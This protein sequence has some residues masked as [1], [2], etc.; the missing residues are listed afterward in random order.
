VTHDLER[1]SA[2]T[3][4]AVNVVLR[5]RVRDIGPDTNWPYACR[6]RDEDICEACATYDE[7]EGCE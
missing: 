7:D 1:V 5:Q 3:L 2:A 6:C 4:D